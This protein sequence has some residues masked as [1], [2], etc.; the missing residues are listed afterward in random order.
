M[1]GAHGVVLGL[2]QGLFLGGEEGQ[3]GLDL[4]ARVDRRQA[5]GDD[6]GD[7]GRRQLAEVGQQGVALLVEFAD[8]ARTLVHR[9][10]V[11]LAGELV[12]DDA[13]LLLHHEDFVQAFGELVHRHRLQRPA[14]A[15]LEHSQAD[16]GAKRLVQAQVVQGLAHVE[17]GLAG[18]DDPQ[19]RV[20]RIQGDLVEVVGAGKGAGGVDLVH[21]QAL[22][23]RQGRVRP[24]DVH[25]VFRQD[26]VLGD[27]HLDPQRVHIHHGG[28]VDVLGDGLE[29][30][31]AAA[32]ARQ[33]PADD[34]VVEDFLDVGR[35]QHRDGGGD[36]GVLALVGDARRLA[37]VVVAGQQQD[38]TVGR[39][40]GRVA[41]LEDIAAAVH[42]RAFAVPHGEHAVVTRAGEQAGL[43]AAP[44]GGS[45]QFFV[46]PWLEVDVVFL[47]EGLGFPEA[48]VEVAERRAAVAGDEAGG[49]Q[50]VRLVPLLLQHRQAGEGLGAGE[51]EVT[52]CETV[53][54]IQADLGQ[55]HA[56]AP[57]VFM[58]T[59]MATVGA[60]FH[61]VPGRIAAA[62][63]WPRR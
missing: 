33:L 6:P 22:F 41:M 25:A 37:A 46:D 38:A 28:G 40:A 63:A 17:I 54:V 26:E 3:A 14:H 29:R 10:V 27:L 60:I 43:L 50:A 44:D 58:A 55:R 62:G 9:P 30:H 52:G 48:L 13:A 31:P 53:F 8:H 4:L 18:G 45:G 56:G 47:E 21:V 19:A 61:S 15:H 35:V 16:L 32:V 57:V 23:L 20:G 49:V 12:L 34:A 7:H 42:T 5:L 59:S 11:E 24:A 36:E 39:Y 51:I 2:G 1:R